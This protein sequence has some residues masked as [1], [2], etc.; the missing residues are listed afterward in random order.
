MGAGKLYRKKTSVGAFDCGDFPTRNLELPGA[1]RSVL[2]MLMFERRHIT[3]GSPTNTPSLPERADI[4]MSINTIQSRRR[5]V[6]TKAEPE[7]RGKASV[8]RS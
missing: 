6:E 3:D 4:W 1:K 7:P 2:V 8:T 5:A